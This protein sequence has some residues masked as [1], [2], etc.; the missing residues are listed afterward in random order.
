MGCAKDFVFISGTRVQIWLSVKGCNARINWGC[1]MAVENTQGS[2][3]SAGVCCDARLMNANCLL[4]CTVGL[5]VLS[6]SSKSAAYGCVVAVKKFDSFCS[7]SI[8][9]EVHTC[10]CRP[11]QSCREMVSFWMGSFPAFVHKDLAN[12]RLP[13]FPLGRRDYMV[14]RPPWGSF[15]APTTNC[16]LRS[17]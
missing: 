8:S 9:V 4:C 10:L 7:A 16:V 13:P 17:L 12:S 5:L 2:G 11:G 1:L 15:P 3:S 14:R 6:S